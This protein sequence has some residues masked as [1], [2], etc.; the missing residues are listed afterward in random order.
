MNRPCAIAIP[1]TS[2]PGDDS[3]ILN[4]SS[5]AADGLYFTGIGFPVYRPYAPLGGGQYTVLNCAGVEF[6]ASSQEEANLLAH[7]NA[8][9]C[10]AQGQAPAVVSTGPPPTPTPGPPSPNPPQPQSPPTTPFSA[11]VYNTPQSAIGSC[12]SLATF[13]ITVPAGLFAKV[14]HDQSQVMAAYAAVDAQALAYAQHR[15]SAFDYCI[16]TTNKTLAVQMCLNVAFGSTNLFVINGASGAVH[17][18]SHGLPPG[19]SLSPGTTNSVLDGGGDNWIFVGN[20]HWMN[21]T[22]GAT[23]AGQP[24]GT[25]S[26]NIGTADLFGV[27]T[28]AGN[29]PFTVRATATTGQTFSEFSGTISVLGFANPKTLP[30]ID[31]CTLM[32]L[33]LQAVGGT[34]PYTFTDPGVLP[35][36]SGLSIQNGFIRG[37]QTAGTYHF[38][39]AVTDSLQQQCT[40]V[41][42]LTVTPSSTPLSIATASPLPNGHNNGIS[43]YTYIQILASTGGCY[44]YHYSLF[45]GTLPNSFFLTF[46]LAS[47]GV[48][49]GFPTQATPGTYSFVLK[50]TDSA[51]QTATKPFTLTIDAD[52]VK[53][54]TC[55]NPP[56]NT[57]TGTA[58]PGS[59]VNGHTYD[60]NALNSMASAKAFNNMVNSGC[61]LCN[62]QVNSVPRTNSLWPSVSPNS[63]VSTGTCPLTVYITGQYCNPSQNLSI[64][65]T[66]LWTMLQGI[67][68]GYTPYGQYDFWSG[69]N[70]NGTLYFSLYF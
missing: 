43:S 37:Q 8:I 28:Q 9:I 65:N 11:T 54:C 1:K 61:S 47:Q 42:A 68:A 55:P 6:S 10:S 33:Q 63:N 15:V 53:T 26:G 67:A 56:H 22:T 66:N 45:S 3:P 58:S 7:A 62:M 40:Q 39:L 19:I 2:C 18:T 34:G 51:G 25:Y 21:Q 48:L 5:E 23:Q 35:L 32:N 64:Q 52:T 4:L 69:P 30:T 41:F 20:N 24:Q 59:D 31:I 12:S 16:G 38:Q 57:G 50:V 27:P 70:G 13:S 49:E 44:P 46:N 60:Q 36:P 17:W 29:F 14:V